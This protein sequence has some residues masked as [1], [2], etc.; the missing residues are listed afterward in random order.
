[1]NMK[2]KIA[3]VYVVY[4]CDDVGTWL[5]LM[6]I[7]IIEELFLLFYLKTLIVNKY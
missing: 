3:V 1:M 2:A 5:Q 6:V 4:I 7:F